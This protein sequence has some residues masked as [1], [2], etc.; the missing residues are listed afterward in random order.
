MTHTYLGP[1]YR[2]KT[3]R[4]VIRCYDPK[5]APLLQKSIQESVEHLR[6]WLPW[7][8]TEPEE[9]KVKIERLRMFRAKFD[10]SENYVYGVFD[11]GETELIGGT[12]LH[13]RVGSNAF[14]I[15]YWVNVNHISKGYA[16][17][18]CAALTK[19]AFEI[20]NVNRVEIHCDPD[21]I[22]SVAIPKK[23]G[24]KYEATL[25]G[26]TETID[27][28]PSDSMIWSIIREEYLKSPAIK[29]KI[30]AYD[31]IGSVILQ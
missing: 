16:T 22:R 15:G 7:V 19:V 6:P 8:K 23:L 26:R 30:V 24:Y 25:R 29:A 28:E 18:F 31:A 21:N 9:L 3:E 2:I 4:L 5:D 11:P 20:E 27:G 10:L 13:P 1:A 14:E 17:E 12:G